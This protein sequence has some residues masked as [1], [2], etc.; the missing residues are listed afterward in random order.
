MMRRELWEE[1]GPA[2]PKEHWDHWMRL[3][4]VFSRTPVRRPRGEP[5]L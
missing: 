3:D 1:L 5:Q 2:W 4:A